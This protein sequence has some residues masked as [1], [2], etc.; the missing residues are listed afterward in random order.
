VALLRSRR[1]SEAEAWGWPA[2]WKE[3]AGFTDDELAGWDEA[4]ADPGPGFVYSLT[5]LVVPVRK[6]WAVVEM[7][8]E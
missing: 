3:A 7:S 5:F 2:R 4:I 1:P 6:K 8:H